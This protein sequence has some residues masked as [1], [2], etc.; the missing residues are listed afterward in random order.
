M[1]SVKVLSFDV[2]IKNLAYCLIEFTPNV[3]LSFNKTYSIK[4]WGIINMMA[5]L[6]EA[7]LKCEYIK[8]GGVK[9]NKPATSFICKDGENIGTCSNKTC[10]KNI[11]D[12]YTGFELKKAKKLLTK[13]MSLFGLGTKV[14]EELDKNPE[15]LEADEVVIEN[16]PVLKNPTMK[17]VQMF[18]YT[19]FIM[20]NKTKVKKLEGINLFSAKNKLNIYDGPE[21]D[22]KK[23]S[24]YATRKAQSVEY[25]KYFLKD[26]EE[27]RKWF[28]DHKKKDDLGDCF[29][30]GLTYYSK[31]KYMKKP[32]T[33]KATKTKK[34]KTETS[35]EQPNQISS[36]N[37]QSNTNTT[38][39][40]TTVVV[41]KPKRT[42]TKKSETL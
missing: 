42:R 24:E 38:S 41:S 33:P 14:I 4:K 23:S 36:S 31:S 19:Y 1:S 18:I 9:C 37:E 27:K 3:D 10:L 25:T 26:N 7:A 15:F 29:L 13:Q 16:Q 2:G 34:T 8:K 12:K 32:K 30:Q 39:I 20:K 35:L 5:D 40:S 22:I 17:S 21:L 28:I 6:E 11:Q